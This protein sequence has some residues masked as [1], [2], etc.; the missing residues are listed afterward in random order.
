V[1]EEVFV[2][3]WRKRWQLVVTLVTAAATTI[4][5]EKVGL[6]HLSIARY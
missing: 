4:V 5:V 3:S 6:R 2:Y 1:L